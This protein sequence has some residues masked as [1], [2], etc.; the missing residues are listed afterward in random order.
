MNGKGIIKFLIIIGVIV[1]VVIF[2]GVKIKKTYDGF[3]DEYKGT[4]ETTDGEDVT[5]EI[6]KGATIKEA[7]QILKDAGLIEY[8]LAF[9]MRIKESKYKDSLQPGTFTLNTGMNLMDMI[10]VLCYVEGTKEVVD[11]LIVPEGY[12]LEQIAAAC[13]KQGIC[14]AQEF[15]SEARYYKDLGIELPFAVDNSGVKYELQGFL[16]PATY[17]IYSDTTAKSLIQDMINAFN[18]VYTD[19]YKAK[20]KELGYTDFEILTMASIVEREAKL[21]SERATIAGVIYNRLEIDMPLQMCPTVLY[22]ITDGMYDKEEVLYDDLEIESNY[23]TYKNAGLPVGPI[24][25]P[26]KASIEAVLYP[27]KHNYLYYHTTG[28]ADGSHVFT[29]TYE[30]HIDT[31]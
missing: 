11:K 5:V 9:E 2:A 10:K 8:K 30:E 13:E 31:Q 22:P 1:A 6:P 20:A 24:C 3:M 25:N 15:L 18:A 28:D 29:E 21:E 12:S 7:A 27:E 14:T 4:D 17:D 16:F 19:E 23:N 26:G